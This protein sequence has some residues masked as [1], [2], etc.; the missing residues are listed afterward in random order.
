MTPAG[1][2]MARPVAGRPRLIHNRALS[3]PQRA[4]GSRIPGSRST[5]RPSGRPTGEYRALLGDLVNVRGRVAQ[6]RAAAVTTEVYISTRTGNS[7][8]PSRKQR[9]ERIY[10]TEA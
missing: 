8:D 9:R 5:T 10:R 7:S 2:R 3:D 6:G 4:R 1:T